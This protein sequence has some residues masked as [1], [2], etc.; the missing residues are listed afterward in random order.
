MISFILI[1]LLIKGTLQIS[2]C[3][4]DVNSTSKYLWNNMQD[5]LTPQSEDD[6]KNLLSH[7]YSLTLNSPVQNVHIEVR[8]PASFV[9]LNCSILPSYCGEV[10]P[11][12]N[13]NPTMIGISISESIYS[14]VDAHVYPM[15]DGNVVSGPFSVSR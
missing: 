1:Y 2:L 5:Y 4:H 12:G 10:L 15:Q 8:N 9:V 11:S 14:N 3:D 6:I 7:L 13:G